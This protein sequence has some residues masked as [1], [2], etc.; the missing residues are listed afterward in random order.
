[1]SIRSNAL[2]SLMLVAAIAAA[3]GG[4]PVSLGVQAGSTIGI[5]VGGEVTSQGNIG[6]GGALLAANGQYDDQRGELVF[7][8]KDVTNPALTYALLTQ[9]VVNAYPDPAS[10]AGIANFV[11]NTFGLHAGLSQ[12]LAIVDIP[13]P[14]DTPPGPPP[15]T[16]EVIVSRR[17]R[18]SAASPLQY[19]WLAAPTYDMGAY[20]VTI[21]PGT[22]TRTP[23]STHYGFLGEIDTSQGIRSLYPYPKVVLALPVTA[24]SLPAAG[25][26]VVSYPAAKLD[27]KTAFEE[28][29]LGREGIVS[30]SDDPQQGFATID[31]VAPER[32]VGQLA[33]AF[34]LVDPFGAGR[35]SLSDFA[36]IAGESRFYDENGQTIA[37][38]SATVGLIR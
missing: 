5:P 24:G 38:A 31:F 26:I 19:A 1:M 7:T 29:H 6:Y 23:I 37:G 22:G 16:Y 15:G 3:C 12:A 35:A 18:T 27:V 28:Q 17:V 34:E 25:R 4:R 32:S 9:A 30:L 14:S 2:P 10:A 36:V 33:L 13:L 21:V 20:R 11:P 8:L